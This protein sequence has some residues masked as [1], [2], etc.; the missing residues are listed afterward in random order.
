MSNFAI[1]KQVL[2]DGCIT[3]YN[4]LTASDKQLQKIKKSLADLP[5]WV[6]IDN[7]VTLKNYFAA[8]E[9]SIRNSQSELSIAWQMLHRVTNM[10]E[11][12]LGKSI[13]M[14]DLPKSKEKA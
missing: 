11:V 8:A 3:V 7:P 6:I 13:H 12:F 4:A 9:M 10:P 5:E 1:N 14:P 2:E